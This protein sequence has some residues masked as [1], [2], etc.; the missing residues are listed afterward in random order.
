MSSCQF[1]KENEFASMKFTNKNLLHLGLSGNFNLLNFSEQKFR[2]SKDLT[3]L[4]SLLDNDS[5]V[6]LNLSGKQIGER[7]VGLLTNF[8]KTSKKIESLTI[9]GF[10]F[11]LNSRTIIYLI[12]HNKRILYNFERQQNIEKIRNSWFGFIEFT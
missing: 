6:S 7:G 3:F 4:K 2:L 5:L 8:L 1:G 11:H 10:K 12:S 9:E